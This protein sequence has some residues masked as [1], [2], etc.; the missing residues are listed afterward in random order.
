[1]GRRCDGDGI[2]ALGEKLVERLEARA[3][4]ELRCARPMRRRR[5]D[6]TDQADAWQTGE[7]ARMVA[8]HHAGTDDADAQAGLCRL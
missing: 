7:H 6:H 5:I 3:I 4:G 1:M 2:D 8:A